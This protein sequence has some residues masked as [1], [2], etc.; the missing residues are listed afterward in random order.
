M[1]SSGRVLAVPM[2]RIITL[3]TT[4]VCLTVTLPLTGEADR[5]EDKVYVAGPGVAVMSNVPSAVPRVCVGGWAPSEVCFVLTSSDTAIEVSIT[6][7]LDLTDM[8]GSLYFEDALGLPVG[9]LQSFCGASPLYGIPTGAQTARVI[10][11]PLSNMTLMPTCAEGVG[12][13]GMVH[14]HVI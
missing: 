4:A 1:S 11:G 8:A 12:T 10:V 6:D 13:M 9:T 7:D 2:N 5:T 14:A 3:L